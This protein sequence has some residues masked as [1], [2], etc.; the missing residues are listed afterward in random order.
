MK[1]KIDLSGLR[2]KLPPLPLGAI[3]ATVERLTQAWQLAES[4]MLILRLPAGWPEA[5]G[6]LAW[7]WRPVQG[8]IEHGTVETLDALPPQVRSGMVQVWTP[9]RD[10]LLT[11]VTLPTR[12][13]ARILQALPY[14]LEEQLL[15]EPESLHFS[16]RPRD[17]GS[18]AVAV[19]ARARLD[20]WMGALKA[21]GLHTAAVCPALFALPLSADDWAL[22]ADG[23]DAYV[24]TGALSGFA[25]PLPWNAPPAV[26][27]VALREAHEQGRAPRELTVWNPPADFDHD[28]WVT[29]LGLPVTVRTESPWETAPAAPFNLLQGELAPASELRQTLQPLRPAAIM[30]ALAF[31]ASVTLNLWEWWQLSSTQSRQRAEMMEL[32]R[33]SF[34]EAKTVVDPVLQMERNL[35]ALQANSGRLAVSDLL[36]LLARVVSAIQGIPQL[37]MRALQYSDATLTLDVSVVDF[38][39]MELLKNALQGRGLRVE[40]VSANSRG[41]GVEARLRVKPGGRT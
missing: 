13:R 11:S 8:A 32:F 23:D 34:P 7:W 37:K 27:A 9:A 29:A 15:G 20:A 39:L 16:Y 17:D 4:G 5:G 26:L 18:L 25:C 35:A 31:G 10:T 6:A 30:L 24:R 3:K 41:T 40:V 14:A 36:P 22:A 28:A 38:Q 33:Q 21:A 1:L 2:A 12:A 19:T